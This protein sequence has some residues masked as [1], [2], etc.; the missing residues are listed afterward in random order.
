MRSIKILLS[1]KFSSLILP[2]FN[3]SLSVN[4]KHGYTSPFVATDN[5]PTP[6]SQIYG[7]PC[8]WFAIELIIL[9]ANEY[10]KLFSRKI[11]S[12]ESENIPSLSIEKSL[13]DEPPAG[14]R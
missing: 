3:F 13:F 5:V 1:N 9:S 11:F 14:T 2:N 12:I 4:M 7:L 10:D 6:A 8:N